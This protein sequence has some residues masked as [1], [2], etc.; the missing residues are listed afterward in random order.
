M[1]DRQN[2]FLRKMV[3][4]SKEKIYRS[5]F[6]IFQFFKKESDTRWIIY[7]IKTIISNWI[8]SKGSI[9]WMILEN[10]SQISSLSRFQL[11][12]LRDYPILF[13]SAKRRIFPDQLSSYP[14]T[15][16]PYGLFQKGSKHGFVTQHAYVATY[17]MVHI[18]ESR[19]PKRE[20]RELLLTW[21]IFIIDKS[22][23][24]LMLEIFVAKLSILKFRKKRNF[25]GFLQ[26]YQI[27]RP[28]LIF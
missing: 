19:N 27:F 23:L 7:K 13:S 3:I 20:T 4:Y 15:F 26:F 25:F 22:T 28:P 5:A 24:T 11:K 9:C 12:Y 21:N 2:F 18:N 8:I 14:E 1:N 17:T 10:W 16:F 6:K